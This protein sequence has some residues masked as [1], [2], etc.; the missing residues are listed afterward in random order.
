M[1]DHKSYKV[2]E[3]FPIQDGRWI[4]FWDSDPSRVSAWRYDY[5]R[6]GWYVRVGLAE[7]PAGMEPRKSWNWMVAPEQAEKGAQK[8][9]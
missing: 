5:A 8:G 4:W 9:Q 7:I 1:E 6:V 2:S 3:K